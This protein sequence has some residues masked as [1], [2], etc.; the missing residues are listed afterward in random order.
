MAPA[1][2]LGH[3]RGSV[4]PGT[5]CR[6]AVFAV[7][8]ATIDCPLADST[9]ISPACAFTEVTLPANSARGGGAW[10]QPRTVTQS[11]PIAADAVIP[12]N[13]IFSLRP[14]FRDSLSKGA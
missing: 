1:S 10:D 2:I 13:L 11:T 4:S 12:Y 8:V 6:M 3:F 14:I 5:A 9:V 7:A